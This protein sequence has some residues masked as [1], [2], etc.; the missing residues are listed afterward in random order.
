MATTCQVTIKVGILP[1]AMVR[2]LLLGEPPLSTWFLDLI[3]YQTPW[4]L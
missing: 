2:E 1:A 3:R 4:E